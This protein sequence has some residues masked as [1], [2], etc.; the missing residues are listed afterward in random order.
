MR[1]SPLRSAGVAH[2]A[3]LALAVLT[4]LALT[5]CGAGS[6]PEPAAATSPT[7]SPMP[8]ATGQ[9]CGTGK[10]A[11][12]VP[13]LV[14]IGQ[15]PVGCPTAMKIERAYAA[16]L[17]SGQAPGNGGGGPVSIKGWV[18][19]GF[20]TPEILRTGDASKCSKGPSEILAV[21]AMPSGSASPSA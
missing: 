21:L 14:E 12:D 6:P 3:W 19:K 2:P 11:A 8:V 17:A 10:T 13:V 9:K 7:Q 16:A 15:G 4:G 18:C 1:R 20:D 5:G